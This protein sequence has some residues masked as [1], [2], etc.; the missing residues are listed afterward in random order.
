MPRFLLVVAYFL[1]VE[2]HFLLV[3]LLALS[4]RVLLILAWMLLAPLLPGPI[5][6]KGFIFL[7]RP[8]RC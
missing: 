5:I 8:A 2:A 4:R 6:K 7:R 1:L 3:P